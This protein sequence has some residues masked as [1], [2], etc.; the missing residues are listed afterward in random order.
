MRCLG[1]NSSHLII[2]HIKAF[3]N[4]DYLGSLTSIRINL[5]FFRV[6]FLPVFLVIAA[7][8]PIKLKLHFKKIIL[9]I[10]FS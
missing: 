3:A 9:L 10:Y 8:T 5:Q 1:K 7:S 4:I 2:K 6:W